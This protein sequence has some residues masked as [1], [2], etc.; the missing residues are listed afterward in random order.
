MSDDPL[1]R[2]IDCLALPVPDLDQALAFYAALGH[3]LV[4]RSA[5]SAGMRL[6]DCDAE[7]VLQ[8]ERSGAE[9]DLTVDAV[10]PAIDRFVDAGGR[11]IVPPFDIAIGMCAVVADPWGNQLV[12][13]DNS[14]GTFTTDDVGNVTGIEQ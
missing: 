9:T 12:L 7:L 1:F 11:V 5:A 4:W 13:L 2:R 8:T 10:G 6:P 3:E 14:K